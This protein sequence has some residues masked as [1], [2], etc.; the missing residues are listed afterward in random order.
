EKL[1]EDLN[2]L[3]T[4]TLERED[5]LSMAHSIE[6]RAPYLDRDVIQTAMRISPRLKLEGRHDGMRKRVHR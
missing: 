4:D 3:Y 6:L 2:Y 5:K 1:W